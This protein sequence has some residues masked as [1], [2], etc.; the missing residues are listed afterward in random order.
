LKLGILVLTGI[1]LWIAGLVLVGL[2][3]GIGIPE[4]IATRKKAQENKA[5]V[6]ME[7]ISRAI[8][9][10]GL[11]GTNPS[12]WDDISPYLSFETGNILEGQPVSSPENLMQEL[13]G[14]GR[15]EVAGLDGAQTTAI[16]LPNGQR[17]EKKKEGA[18]G[19]GSGSGL[20]PQD[21][22][23]RLPY[24]QIPA[25]KLPFTLEA[26]RSWKVIN[27]APNQWQVDHQSGEKSVTFRI[28]E[29]QEG[30]ESETGGAIWAGMKEAIKPT[31]LQTTTM[32][33]TEIGGITFSRIGLGRPGNGVEKVVHIGLTK[34]KVWVIEATSEKIRPSH[35][36]D[37][38][39]LLAGFKK[40]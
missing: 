8:P 19:S 6:V 2:T 10:A 25:K 3:V 28:T 29:T 13:F 36:V 38:I 40:P 11:A 27:P 26:S 7:K 33:N 34:N 1:T 17:I 4:L 15:L 32:E 12:T 39:A 21:P 35:D 9:R 14:G 30:L 18:S 23:E 5:Q 22:D 20:P 37:I 16:T 24:E 31:G